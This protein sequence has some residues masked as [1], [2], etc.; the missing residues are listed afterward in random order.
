MYI[1][2]GFFFFFWLLLLYCINAS[3]IKDVV[4]RI[5]YSVVKTLVNWGAMASQTFD[6]ENFRLLTLYKY[7]YK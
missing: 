4:I 1:L 3:Y 6:L 5:F 7:I 2:L